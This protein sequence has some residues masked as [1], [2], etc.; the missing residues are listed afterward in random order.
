MCPFLKVGEKAVMNQNDVEVLLSSVAAG[1]A[2]PALTY[3]AD[4]NDSNEYSNGS[5]GS[6]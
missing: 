3:V 1:S 2:S 5:P 6:L 4:V